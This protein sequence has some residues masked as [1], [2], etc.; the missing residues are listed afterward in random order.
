MRASGFRLDLFCSVSLLLLEP[1]PE[2]ELTDLFCIFARA[3]SFSALARS[4]VLVREL[5]ASSAHLQPR[6]L[7]IRSVLLHPTDP[8]RARERRGHSAPPPV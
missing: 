2:P 7:R 8:V 1:E 4:S 6:F 3:S 5:P